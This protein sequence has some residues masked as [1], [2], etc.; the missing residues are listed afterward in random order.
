MIFLTLKM[1]IKS[2]I[3]R[4]ILKCEVADIAVLNVLI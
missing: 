3:K 2:G 4:N 1:D